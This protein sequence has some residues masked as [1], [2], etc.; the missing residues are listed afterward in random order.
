ML[1]AISAS[2]VPE[3]QKGNDAAR[4]A[5]ITLNTVNVALFGWQVLTGFDILSK[6]W[7]KTPW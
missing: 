2:L 5:H 6:V 4:I 3:M 7:E 1:W